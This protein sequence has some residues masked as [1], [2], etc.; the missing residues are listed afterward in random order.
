MRDRN[1]IVTVTGAMDPDPSLYFQCHEHLLLAKGQ[2]FLVDPALCLDDLEKSKEEALK[3]AKKGG[4]GLVDA[5]P[6][7]CG[8]MAEGLEQISRFAGIRIVASTGFHKMAFYP[9]KHWIFSESEDWLTD[10]F[11][12]ELTEGMY[13][14]GDEDRP[15]KQ[16]SIRAGQ[17]KTAMEHAKMDDQYRKLFGAAAAAAKET[18]APIMVHVENGHQ[19]MEY[20]EFLMKQGIPA[21]QMITRFP[22]CMIRGKEY[23]T[24]I[25]LA[26]ELKIS[27]AAVSTYKNRNGC[28]GILETLCQMQKEERETYFL[29]GRAV[30]YKELMQMGYTS[31]SYQTV[32]KKKIP[33]YPQLAGH[34]FVTGCVDV[35][36][37]YEE[38]KSER[39]EQEKGMQMNM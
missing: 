29:D 12:R 27:A 6:V 15:M 34:D 39:L 22:M 1:K 10:L 38:V 5:Q 8:R 4:S 20:F 35:A 26:A 32:P 17:I 37:I 11:I 31:V 14:D 18:G 9:E 30:S 25:E 33:L 7:G 3:Y 28:G 24:L 13:E 36:K 23:R 16:T 21:E 2:S 19:P